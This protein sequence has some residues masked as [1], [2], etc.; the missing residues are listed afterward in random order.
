M[1]ILLLS[2]VAVQ[3]NDPDPVRWM[4]IYGYGA[5]VTGMAI[6]KRYTVLAPIGAILYLAG[7]IYWIPGATVADPSHI[8]TDLQMHEK[9][10]EEVR[11]AVGLLLCAVWM[12][13]LSVVWLRNRRTTL[14]G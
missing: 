9:G 2:C 5:L 10:V 14:T 8:F 7:F 11:E 1:L 6:A 12:T 13:V 3:Y 4:L